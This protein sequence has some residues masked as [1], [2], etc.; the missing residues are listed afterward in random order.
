[1]SMAN[2]KIL[3]VYIVI[4]MIKDNVRDIIAQVDSESYDYLIL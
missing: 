1:M 3:L 4:F 2:S